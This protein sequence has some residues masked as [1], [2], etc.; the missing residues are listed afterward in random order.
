[1]GKSHPANGTAWPVILARVRTE[2][3][4]YRPLIEA[5]LQVLP[6]YM[7]DE[8]HGDAGY[9]NDPSVYAYFMNFRIRTPH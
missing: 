1:M 5:A 6:G 8:E 2:I 3:A 4:T 9:E 7:Y